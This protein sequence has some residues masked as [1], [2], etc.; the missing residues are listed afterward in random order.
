MAAITLPP[1]PPPNTPPH[2]Q[3]FKFFAY[4]L[5]VAHFLACFFWMLADF[6]PGCVDYHL[7]PM[8][9]P[10]ECPNWRDHYR[11]VELKPTWQYF[12]SLY[13]AITT[14]TTIG[15]GDIVPQNQ[16]EICYVMF[17][18]LFGYAFARVD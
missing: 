15:Y 4:M 13:W 6:D 11:L 7:D 18:E 3:A 1:H 12:Q 17:A 5:L 16:S 9:A 2:W 10:L 8:T 14:M